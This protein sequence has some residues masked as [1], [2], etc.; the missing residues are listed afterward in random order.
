MLIYKKKGKI[1]HKFTRLSTLAMF[2]AMV[3]GAAGCSSDRGPADLIL[4]HNFGAAYTNNIK[5]SLIDPIWNN[6]KLNVK[7]TSKGSYQGILEA[8]SGTLANRKFP[9]IATGYPD[10]LSTYARSGYPASP[11]GVLLNLNDY[12]DDP[13]LNE[14]H[15]AKTGYT[16]REDYYPEYMIENNTICYDEND[17][18][19]TV[20]LPFNKSTEV[21][22][23][24]G[25]F[26]DYVRKQ[27]NNPDLPVPTT[28][29]EWKAL[30][31]KL[32]EIQLSLNG[33]Y[34]CGDKN[35]EGTASNFH[36]ETSP[37]DDVLLDFS[38]A[39]DE[40]TA[41]L[42]WDSMANM[43]I[44]L[45]RQFDSQFTSYTTEDRHQP[46]IVDRH[47]YMEFFSGDNKAKTV[48][49]MQLVRDLSGDPE[50]V[51]ERIFATP[52]FFGG[53]YASD[54]FAENKVLFVVCSTGGLSYNLNEG[55]RFR[56]APIPYLDAE[57]KYVISQGANMTIFE[58]NS[59][60]KPDDY[61]LSQVSKMAFDTV[62]KMTTGDYQAKWA[63]LTGY[64]PASKS[65]AES[66]I[67]TDF[68]DG[69]SDYSD[70]ER[71]AYQ[72]GARLNQKEY[73]NAEKGWHKF[74]DPGFDGSATIRDKADKI[75]P[76]IIN[77]VDKSI[78]DIL[79]SYYDDAALR[80]FVRK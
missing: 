61:N 40:E 62:V 17:K 76:S 68:I 21:I 73:M 44:T 5:E 57:H 19:I 15:K 80:K 67:Y 10:H 59:E 46:Q 45:V 50:K 34:L 1:M 33:K 27:V 79:Q 2:G 23:Y 3:V 29:A 77:D 72:E 42:S 37:T 58:R 36:V 14:A 7:A 64:Y 35:E 20:G 43:F 52:T 56:V 75:I 78:E 31:P 8:V 60:E 9:N 38:E 30:G 48:A 65:A 24:N 32:R 54:A 69:E 71:L 25:V 22:G 51:D 63:T 18:E 28:W 13:A 66:K 6:E 16:L 12:L 55:Q 74:V 49:A 53:S 41:V 4:W 70:I 47:G 26:M 11:T 39:K